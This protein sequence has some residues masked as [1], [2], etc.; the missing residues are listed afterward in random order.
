MEKEAPQ[1][2]F[3]GHGHYLLFAAMRIILPTEGDF[4][5][6]NLNEPMVGNGDAVGIAGEIVQYMKRSAERRFGM[7]SNRQFPSPLT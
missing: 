4:S 7:K 3:S 1:E 2:L 6:G 5:I